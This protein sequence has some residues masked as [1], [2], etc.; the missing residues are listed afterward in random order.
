[1]RLKHSKKITYREK[2]GDEW[3]AIYAEEYEPKTW[4]IGCCIHKAKRAQN[5]WYA[6]RKNKRASKIKNSKTRRNYKSITSLWKAFNAT[7]SK[8]DKR[9]T[10]IIY[11]TK[12]HNVSTI[13]KYMSKL[14]FIATPTD[15]GWFWVRLP[16]EQ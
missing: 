8:I 15:I 14:K 1:M 7:I 3:I 9:E 6:G 2:L 11:T 16:A 4:N 5:D 13:H 12:E 10:I